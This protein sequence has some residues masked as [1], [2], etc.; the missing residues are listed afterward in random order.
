M[1]IFIRCER[2]AG[3]ALAT[4]FRDHMTKRSATKIKTP[5]R[6]PRFA[7]GTLREVAGDKVF[8]RG[9]EYHQG[10]QVDIVSIEKTRVVAK[11]VGSEIY[12]TELNGAGSKF[13]R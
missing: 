11:V 1:G 12:R 10:K 9:A 13:S 5:A 4:Q 7:V 3:Q 2:A 6:S 8:G